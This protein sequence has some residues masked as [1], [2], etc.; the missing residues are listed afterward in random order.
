[1]HLRYPFS[2]SLTRHSSA[3]Q[4]GRTTSSR[5]QP[6][7]ISNSSSLAPG[8]AGLLSTETSE[9]SECTSAIDSP[10]RFPLALSLSVFG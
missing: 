10:L 9:R 2:L 3:Y 5:S 4:I 1:M 8:S 6:P 7:F